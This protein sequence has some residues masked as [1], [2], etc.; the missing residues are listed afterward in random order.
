MMQ[1]KESVTNISF[2]NGG[3]TFDVMRHTLDFE[4]ESLVVSGRVK[5]ALLSLSRE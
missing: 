3:N 1:L 5:L 2:T 4:T